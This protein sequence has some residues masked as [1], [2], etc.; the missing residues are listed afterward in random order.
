MD[1]GIKNAARWGPG[2]ALEGHRNKNSN[3]NITQLPAPQ[4]VRPGILAY[5][6]QRTPGEI[7]AAIMRA[8]D[9]EARLARDTGVN[10]PPE[11]LSDIS[12]WIGRGCLP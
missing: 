4:R 10:T 1:P 8:L 12:A 7:C 3:S 5:R 11:I 9:R 6:Q 2:A